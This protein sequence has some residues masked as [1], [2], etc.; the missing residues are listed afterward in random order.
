M[1]DNSREKVVESQLE[2]LER[3]SSHGDPTKLPYAVV[4]VFTGTRWTGNPLAVVLDAGRLTASDMQ[5]I[6][7][8][9]NLSETTFVCRRPKS[10]EEKLGIRVRIFTTQEELPFAG[11]PTLGTAWLLR[12]AHT[13]ATV[14]LDLNGGKIPVSFRQEESGLFGEMVQPEPA[15]GKEHP[16]DLIAEMVGVKPRD[17][18]DDIPIQTVST[19][20]PNIIVPFKTLS[21]I[22]RVKLDFAAIESYCHST[23]KAAG[24][25]LVTRETEDPSAH[26][27][28]RHILKWTEDPVTG[29]AG[30]ACIA[31]MVRH[32]WASSEERIMIEQGSEA[33]RRGAMFGSALL[34]NE[35]VTE[36]RLGGQC[37]LSGRGE[38]EI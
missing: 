2:T 32:G 38:L 29:S 8:E 19:G 4:D 36:I 3:T 22:Q 37:V 6:A 11:H 9:M 7:R 21:A 10:I 34:Q 28:A 14:T 27:H 12:S 33:G 1:M 18:V 26:I 15:F 23:D 17:L 25:Y 13:G 16:V 35:T 20:L 5:A 24:L 30:G 31:W